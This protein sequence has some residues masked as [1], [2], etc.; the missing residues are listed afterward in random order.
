ML[1]C[2]CTDWMH[3][4]RKNKISAGKGAVLSWVCITFMKRKNLVKAVGNDAAY[5]KDSFW[6]LCLRLLADESYKFNKDVSLRRNRSFL[7]IHLY[8]EAKLLS[9]KGLQLLWKE[10]THLGSYNN[11]GL[12]STLISWR[13]CL[14]GL[15]KTLRLCWALMDSVDY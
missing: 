9:G 10:W 1:W 6:N 7:N 11:M 15:S 8:V 2:N 4:F 13:V 12:L 3:A 14:K 5:F